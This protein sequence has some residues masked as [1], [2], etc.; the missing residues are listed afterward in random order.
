ME[1]TQPVQI[2]IKVLVSKETNDQIQFV[3]ENLDVSQDHFVREAI[4]RNLDHYGSDLSA[5]KERRLARKRERERWERQ[6]P[7]RFFVQ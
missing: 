5:L 4:Q 1:K 3:T 6:R 7:M 2:K